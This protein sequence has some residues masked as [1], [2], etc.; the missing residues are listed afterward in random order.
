MF[1]LWLQMSS[2]S[3][4]VCI[5]IFRVPWDHGLHV[6]MFCLFLLFCCVCVFCLFVWEGGMKIRT[7]PLKYF[8]FVYNV[9][10]KK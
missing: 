8:C 5:I 7:N 9:L 2:R 3:K 10:L 6:V 4:F 1:L